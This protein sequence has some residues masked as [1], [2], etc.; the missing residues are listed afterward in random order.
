VAHNSDHVR[1]IRTPELREPVIVA[2]FTGWNDAG[3]AASNAVRHMV[4]HW[5]A[6][7]LAEIDP[8]EF[9]DFAT[10]RPHVR[11]SD[12]S[13]RL[14][15]P[16][17]GLW[18]ATTPG[19]DL[20]LV[21]GP[22]PALRWRAF[23]EQLLAVAERFQVK[24]IITLGALLADVSHRRDVQVLGTAGDD[25]TTD[26]HQLQRSRYEGPTGIVGVLGNAATDDGRHAVSLWAAVPAY[27]SQVSSPIAAAALVRR[28]ADIIG[29]PAPVLA[30]DAEAAA[31]NRAV[32]DLLA[33]DDEL[34][35]FVDRLENYTDE[36]DVFDT[37]DDDADEDESD[38]DDGEQLTLDTETAT[39]PASLI[40][41]VE[42][43][44]RDQRP[45]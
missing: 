2:A 38:D 29:T 14:M 3:D 5:Q 6:T 40:D 28:A 21:L 34:T 42:R 13:R 37:D 4:E 23:T 7:P 27:A 25:S 17:V 8:E 22:E 31:Y 30:L 33:S 32:E 11:L 41:E 26:R 20:I 43:F 10:V 39:D 16:T 9:T 1:W 35:T 44:L 15:W 24:T 45:D 36:G 12:G 18:S 19:A